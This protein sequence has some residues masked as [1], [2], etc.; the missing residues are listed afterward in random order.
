MLPLDLSS[1][2]SV[3]EVAKKIRALK[4]PIDVLILNVCSLSLSLCEYERFSTTPVSFVL[5][6]RAQAG[7]YDY[8]QHCTL[9]GF[10][11]TL[12]T[13]VRLLS[14]SLSLSIVPPSDRMQR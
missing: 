6:F 11:Q 10:E 13:S 1:L 9:D 7:V 12:R 14:L 8:E 3:R 5:T 4:K 2:Q